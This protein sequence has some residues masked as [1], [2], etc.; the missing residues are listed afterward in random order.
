[1][2]A[3]RRRRATAEEVRRMQFETARTVIFG[4]KL[5][6]RTTANV[7]GPREAWTTAGV[8]NVWNAKLRTPF[9][10]GTATL[11]LSKGL[12][13][14]LTRAQVERN[15]PRPAILIVVW[16]Q[17]AGPIIIEN[18]ANEPVVWRPPNRSDSWDGLMINHRWVCIGYLRED[19][20]LPVIPNFEELLFFELE[21]DPDDQDEGIHRIVQEYPTD[22]R[23]TEDGQYGAGAFSFGV[24]IINRTELDQGSDQESDE[25]GKEDRHQFLYTIRGDWKQLVPQP[26]AQAPYAVRIETITDTVLDFESAYLDPEWDIEDL[27]EPVVIPGGLGTY[28]IKIGIIDNTKA[29]I[30]YSPVVPIKQAR[31]VLDVEVPQEFQELLGPP[32]DGICAFKRKVDWY[33]GDEG[34]S[35]LCAWKHEDV[36]AVIYAQSYL[37]HVLTGPDRRRY[38]G[39]LEGVMA[40]SIEDAKETQ[41]PKPWCRIARAPRL[42]DMFQ[43]ELLGQGHVPFVSAGTALRFFNPSLALRAARVLQEQDARDALAHGPHYGA[44]LAQEPDPNPDPDEDVQAQRRPHALRRADAMSIPLDRFDQ[45]EFMGCHVCAV[46]P[47]AFTATKVKG[48]QVCS[49]QCYKA[50]KQGT[51]QRK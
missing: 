45:Y 36:V 43:V 39:Y 12:V 30:I 44:W 48:L 7:E 40:R 37:M 17:M 49:E 50:F 38:E 9:Q 47:V 10:L 13:P 25:A 15:E 20:F 31:R 1:M 28:R 11:M 26:G 21:V 18:R 5:I 46:A 6:R 41:E 24:Q 35:T 16:M 42:N 4:D 23:V 51:S 2:D 29:D 22:F 33:G 32:L 34:V 3:P 8:V 19:D 14:V 27:L